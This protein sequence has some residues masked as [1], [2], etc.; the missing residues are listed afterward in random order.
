MAD[1]FEMLAA[2]EDA[3]QQAEEKGEQ[4]FTCP[5]CGGTAFWSRASGNDHLH[6]ACKGC[7][8]RML[9]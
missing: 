2:Y 7:G 9:E 1:V 5:L 6:S 4:Y 3:Q 8:F